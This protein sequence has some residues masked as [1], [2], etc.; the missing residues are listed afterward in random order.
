MKLTELQALIEAKE[1]HHATYRDLDKLWEGLHI[2][3][4]KDVDGFRGF[5]HCGVFY[6]DSEEL[7]A[8][9]KMVGAYSVGSYGQG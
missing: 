3:K 1:F 7:D 9:Q 6:K 4:K 2:Y 5:T 8:A